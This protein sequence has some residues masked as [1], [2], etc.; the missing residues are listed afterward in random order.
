[1]LVQVIATVSATDAD[2]TQHTHVEYQLMP[3]DGQLFTVHPRTYAPVSLVFTVIALL[4]PYLLWPCV[5]ASVCLSVT[6]RDC[7]ETPG[8]IELVFGAEV[9]VDLFY[10]V[11]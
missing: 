7:V 4:P 9:S 1:V 8:R 11:L 5:C 10:P 3:E 2:D 6:S